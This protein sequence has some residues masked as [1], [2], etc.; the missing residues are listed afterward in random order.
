M[1][2]QIRQ[3][4]KGAFPHCQW[5]G[6]FGC[7]DQPHDN[8]GTVK[9]VGKPPVN[10]VA[11][12]KKANHE[13]RADVAV[14]ARP[15]TQPIDILIPLGPG[16]HFADAEIRYALRSI[17]RYATGWRHIVIVGHIPEFLRETDRIRLVWRRE[18]RGN[19]A[20]RISLKVQWAF[21]NLDLTETV[22]FWNDDYLL[23]APIDVRTIPNYYRGTLARK[24]TGTSGSWQRTLQ[25][26]C[27][28][29]A[30][31]KRPTL[32]YDIHV[33]IRFVRTPFL[34]LADW[35]ERSRKHPRGFVMKSVYGNHCCHRESATTKDCKLQ[36]TWSPEQMISLVGRGRWIVSYGDGAL[37]QGF[38]SWMSRLLP[39]PGSWEK[40]PIQHRGNRR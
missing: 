40:Q 17:Q 39:T 11:P 25:D 4:L 23:I 2:R 30:A 21:E 28:A 6:G 31:V 14:A 37:Q 38:V 13:P 32:H 20:S 34:Q 33:P 3:H 26:T 22:A 16:S 8:N 12:K 18:F 15:Q 29:L 27:D 36:R 10:T 1:K 9:N 7:M 24:I 35:W 5:C 19:K